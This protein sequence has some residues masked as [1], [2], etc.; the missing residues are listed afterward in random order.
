MTVKELITQLL[1]APLDS[2]VYT[3]V[4]DGEHMI[5][6]KVTTTGYAVSPPGYGR[7][8]FLGCGEPPESW[9]TPEA[10]LRRMGW[11]D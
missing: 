3:T 9:P 4:W 11:E 7:G 10:A 2:T 8:A 5:A 6:Q 1:D